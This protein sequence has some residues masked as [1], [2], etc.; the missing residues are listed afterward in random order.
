M[1][2]VLLTLMVMLFAACGH[3][4]DST[5]P[6]A[7]LALSG[8]YSGRETFTSGRGGTAT[9]RGTVVTNGASFSGSYSNSVGDTGTVS[10]TISGSTFTGSELSTTLG[11]T[12]S[13]N[14]EIL[15]GGNAFTFTSACS[16]GVGA[17]GTLTRT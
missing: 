15:N 10:G 16:N 7:N 5:G 6:S 9:L 3:S 14:G 13:F 17:V 2:Y 4:G 12:C 1:H 11:I 8:A